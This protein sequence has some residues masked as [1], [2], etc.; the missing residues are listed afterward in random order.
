MIVRPWDAE[1]DERGQQ[2]DPPRA[3]PRLRE[4]T[5]PIGQIVGQNLL[6]EAVRDLHQELAAIQAEQERSVSTISGTLGQIAQEL[7]AVRDQLA[8]LTE[9]LL[10][11]VESEPAERGGTNLVELRETRERIERAERQV[12]LL[13]RGLDSVDALRAQVEVHNR[14]IGRLTE[15]AAD[16]SPRVDQLRDDLE[17]TTGSLQHTVSRLGARLEAGEQTVRGLE[18]TLGTAEAGARQ[19][20]NGRRLAYALLTLGL[21]PGLAVAVW[22]V[23]QLLGLVPGE[24]PRPLAP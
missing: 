10:R 15:L 11:A 18:L 24:P 19:A 1:A 21:T 23:L 13:V 16:A 9:P 20:E 2:A 3:G 4:Q 8:A 6:D 12:N 17:Q 14:A 5:S 22:V 7:V